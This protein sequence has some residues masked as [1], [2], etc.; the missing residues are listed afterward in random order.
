M[1][2]SPAAIYRGTPAS[3]TADRAG[4]AKDDE[5]QTDRAQGNPGLTLQEG[6]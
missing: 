4:D 5:Q 3:D 6:R 1:A 2:A